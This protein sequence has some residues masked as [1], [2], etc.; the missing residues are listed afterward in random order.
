[1]EEFMAPII[2]YLG[3]GGELLHAEQGIPKATLDIPLLT[4]GRKL[5]Q[6]IENLQKD[7]IT[8]CFIL[9]YIFS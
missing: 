1:M 3:Q 8:Y 5:P 2:L 4:D 6:I 9:K 7:R